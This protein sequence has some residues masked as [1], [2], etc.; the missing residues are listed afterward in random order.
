M[1]CL[2]QRVTH[3]S[4][5]IDDQRVAQI[6]SG[7]LVFIG[8][9]SDDTFHHADKALQKILSM[10]LFED[11]DNK[12]NRSLLQIRGELL[13][14]SQFTLMAKL[15]GNR[16]SFSTAAEPNHAQL[17]Y[18]YF[19]KNAKLQTSLNSPS[20]N[21]CSLKKVESGVFGA[22]MKILLVNNG[23]VTIFQEY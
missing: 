18:D 14:V 22:D 12:L 8:I 23:P 9:A 16:P 11:R 15:K 7:L 3:A 2:L 6:D 21:S 17:I 13:I 19:V 1:R 20:V 4:V 10:R 5:S